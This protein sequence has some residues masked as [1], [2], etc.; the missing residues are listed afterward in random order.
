MVFPVS[1]DL[2]DEGVDTA[3]SWPDGSWLR[4]NMVATIDGAAVGP[5]GRSASISSPADKELFGRLRATADVVLVGAGTARAE[6]YG[7]ARRRERY[8]Q[9]RVME[10]RAPAPVI[11]V[12]TRS[13]RLD[14]TARLFTEVVEG[15]PR[16]TPLVITCASALPATRERLGSVAEVVSCGADTVDLVQM[17]TELVE[18]G[19]PRIHCEGGPRLLGDLLQA[20]LL[21]E[22]LVTT[23]PLLRGAHTDPI[24]ASGAL[25]G[26][27]LKHLLEAEGSLFARWGLRGI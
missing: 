24:A 17:R 15:L 18:R 19:L 11:A 16:S 5:D 4:A 27:H 10:G 9:Q 25:R 21:D 6:D 12:V 8:T 3:Y 14:P 7:P 26:A 2:D 20:G 23:T 1:T 13:G 22:L